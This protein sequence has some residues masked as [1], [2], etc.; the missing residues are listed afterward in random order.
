[1]AADREQFVFGSVFRMIRV[2]GFELGLRAP[3]A[4]N[5]S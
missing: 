4:L 1:M 3:G 2:I 5:P